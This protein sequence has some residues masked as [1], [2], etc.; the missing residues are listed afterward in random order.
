MSVVVSKHGIPYF[1]EDIPEDTDKKPEVWKCVYYDNTGKRWKSCLTKKDAIDFMESL[2]PDE[3]DMDIAN[4]DRGSSFCS[5]FIYF[6]WDAT[7][8]HDYQI[9]PI[10]LLN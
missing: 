6:I 9:D 10:E 2:N 8:G 1:I 7:P 5:F 3:V 4:R